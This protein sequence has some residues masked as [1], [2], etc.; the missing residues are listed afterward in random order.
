MSPDNGVL[1]MGASMQVTVE[2]QSLVVGA[3]HTDMIL[4]YDTGQCPKL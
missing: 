3:H 4:H 2:Y 1:A